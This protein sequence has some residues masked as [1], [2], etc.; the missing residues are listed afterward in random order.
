M[1]L[2]SRSILALKEVFAQLLLRPYMA[3]LI[4]L[5]L[6]ALCRYCIESRRSANIQ[7]SS[8]S[9]LHTKLDSGI[10]LAGS[11]F[12]ELGLSWLLQKQQSLTASLN[13]HGVRTF[14]ENSESVF[15]SSADV[16][17]DT[18]TIISSEAEQISISQVSG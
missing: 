18:P 6:P 2:H 13:S 8:Q 7:A 10:C 15:T 5:H 9:G 1:V 11:A 14:C 3:K 4:R 17:Q 16:S 12:T